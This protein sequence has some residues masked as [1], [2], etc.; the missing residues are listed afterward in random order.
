MAKRRKPRKIRSLFSRL[1]NVQRRLPMLTAQYR[2]DLARYLQVIV[3]IYLE[4]REEPDEFEMFCD[5][6]FWSEARS[7]PTA[8]NTSRLLYF[9]LLFACGREENGPKDASFYNTALMA[10]LLDKI[11]KEKIAEEITNRGGLRAIVDE[12]RLAK[13]Q[14]DKGGN[15]ENQ[16]DSDEDADYDDD[17][18]GGPPKPGEATEDGEPDENVF[19]GQPGKK[20]PAVPTRSSPKTIL[21]ITGETHGLF[22][23]TTRE[24]MEGFCRMTDGEQKSV[25]I[26]CIGQEDNGFVL[27]ELIDY[28]VE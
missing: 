1:K 8:E 19:N 25:E 22:I 6:E 15:G 4:I 20:T 27:F 9:L 16:P 7:R 23:E 26:K 5:D 12:Y 24:E 3:I 17:L 10:L 14:G 11:P 13:R 18:S 2:R 28:E 21:K